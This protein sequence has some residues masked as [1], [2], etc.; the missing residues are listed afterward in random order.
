MPATEASKRLTVGSVMHM[1]IIEC[2]PQAPL[3]DVARGR[4]RKTPTAL[5]STDWAPDRLVRSSAG[6][7]SYP[8]ST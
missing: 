3:E 2:E 7:A 6:G 8:T 4:P 1:G 5:P